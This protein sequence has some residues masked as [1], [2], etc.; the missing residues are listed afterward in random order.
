MQKVPSSPVRKEIFRE[1]TQ[2]YLR[3]EISGDEYF[4]LGTGD[5]DPA[6]GDF[7]RGMRSGGDHREAGAAAAR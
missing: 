2:R 6:P 1:D 3:G 4:A 7:F 5:D